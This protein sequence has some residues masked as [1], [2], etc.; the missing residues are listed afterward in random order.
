MCDLQE[1]LFNA[2][3]FCSVA[4]WGICE[5]TYRHTHECMYTHICIYMYIYTYI[6]MYT[7]AYTICIPI[8][9][10]FL[11]FSCQVMSDSDSLRP[12]GLQHARLPCSLLSLRI[13]L[14]SCLVSQW[15]YLAILSSATL[16]F[17]CFQSFSASQSFPM[18]WLSMP[19]G[20]STRV[21][22]SSSVYT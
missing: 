3:F 20:Q 10:F 1:F 16:F 15:C 9:I 21:S 17:F 19:R 18:S 6:Y 5:Y 22:A 12:H 11:F 4:K 13:C 7:H 8:Y 2:G 14:N